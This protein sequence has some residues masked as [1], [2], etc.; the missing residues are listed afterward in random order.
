MEIYQAKYKTGVYHGYVIKEKGE[1]TL[2]EVQQVIK[3]PKQGDLHQ[4]YEAEVAHFHQRK[5][6]AEKEKVWVPTSTVKHVESD[7]LYD[8]YQASLEHAFQALYEKMK[9]RN[10]AYSEQAL[11]KLDD[12]KR[13]YKFAN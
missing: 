7:F 8:D 2:F 10:D 5:A 13:D 9:Q 4:P 3:H 1:Q 6:L 12:L 11:L